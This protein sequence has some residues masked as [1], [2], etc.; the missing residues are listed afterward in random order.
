MTKSELLVTVDCPSMI[1]LLVVTSLVLIS[2]FS[3]DFHFGPEILAC[4]A[5][6]GVIFRRPRSIGVLL[7]V[8]YICSKSQDH[9]A[10]FT[11]PGSKLIWS[12]Y[13]LF[14]GILVPAPTKVSSHLRAI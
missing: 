10:V 2:I 14:S 8:S 7:C 11:D 9:S 1:D 12:Y 5:D 3:K 13:I 6:L 4:R